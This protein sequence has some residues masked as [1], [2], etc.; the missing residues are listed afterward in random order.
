MRRICAVKYEIHPFPTQRFHT[1][2]Q[3][4]RAKSDT[5]FTKTSNLLVRRGG[6]LA[7]QFEE[8]VVS[9]VMHIFE[10][11][12]RESATWVRG[13][14]TALERPL[15]EVRDQM[16]QRV[17]GIEQIKVA[18]LDLAERIA[19]LQARMDMLKK[20]H[21]ALA[22]ARNNLERFAEKNAAEVA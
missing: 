16:Q 6:S 14:Y 5:E 21:S 9:R 11:V 3:K 22:D 8:L 18:E 20:K 10:I 4:A 15:L 13:L 12:S 2:L 19:E 1:E 7:E 17:A